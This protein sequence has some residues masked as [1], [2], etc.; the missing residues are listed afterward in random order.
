[1]AKD[2]TARKLGIATRI[3]G[4]QIGKTRTYGAI[5]AATKATY[6]HTKRVTRQLWLEVTGFVFLALAGIGAI[7]FVREYAKFHAG[8]A[9]AN[10]TILAAC[11]A[12]LFGWFGLSSFWRVNRKG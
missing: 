11:F 8:H 2:S 7:A 4:Q 9:D 10:R 1:M 12:V 6:G 5:S 3:A